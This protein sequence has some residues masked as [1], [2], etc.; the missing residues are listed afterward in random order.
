MNKD[1]MDFIFFYSISILKKIKIVLAIWILLK[2]F[3]IKYIFSIKVVKINYH[4]PKKIN[5]WEEKFEN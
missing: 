3:I 4:G 5:G 2:R 1:G